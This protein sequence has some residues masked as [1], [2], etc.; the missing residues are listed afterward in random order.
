M[1]LRSPLGRVRGLGSAKQGVSH[2]LWQRLTAVALV[3]LAI[4]FVISVVSLA[5]ADYSHFRTWLSW[6]GNTT[7]MILLIFAVFRHAQLGVQVVV[8]DYV[9]DAGLKL[10]SLIAVKFIALFFGVFAAVSVLRVVFVGG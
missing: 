9:H 4:W 7:L 10:V 2:F 1:S 8:E 3:P 6:P 5:G